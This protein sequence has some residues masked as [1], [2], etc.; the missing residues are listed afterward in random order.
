MN[1]RPSIIVLLLQQGLDINVRRHNLT[2]VGPS[3]LHL[4]VQCGAFDAVVCLV[5]N[6]AQLNAIDNNGW[7]P[8]HCAAFYNQASI[9]EVFLRQDKEFTEIQTQDNL[10][11]TPLLLAATSGCLPTIT[12]LLGYN[13]DVTGC[14]L[15]GH[16]VI[17][18]AVIHGHTRIVQY[19]IQLDMK[20]LP[21]WNILVDM[22]KFED[23]LAQESAV[24]CMEELILTNSE[25]WI[26]IYNSDGVTALANLFDSTSK[27]VVALT[28]SVLCNMTENVEVQKLLTDMNLGPSLVHLLLSPVGD[29][30]ARIS[31]II[32]D[33]ASNIESNQKIFARQGV[34]PALIQLLD[35]DMEDVLLN[36]INAIR[37][38]CLS[39]PSNQ[40]EVTKCNG[41]EPLVD[42]LSINSDNNFLESAAAATLA[43]I[44]LGHFE[45]QN[46]I[47]AAG[48]AE[49]LVN[50]TR[51]RNVM[52][53]VKG[54]R[55]IEALTEKNPN[56]QSVFLKLGAAE[57]LVQ[58]LK[59][60]NGN[61]REQ[62]AC[63]LWALAGHTR[64]QQKIIAETIGI[65]NIIKML[66]E[67][68]SE[69]L[70][71]VGCLSAIGLVKEDLVNQSNMVKADVLQQLVR[72]LN[73]NHLSQQVTTMVVKVLGVLCIGVAYTNNEFVQSKIAE[74]G[75]I[76]V[77][78]QRQDDSSCPEM[79]VEILTT[80][81]CIVLQNQNNQ[82][83]LSNEM[84]FNW[85]TLRNLLQSPKQDI[86]LRSGMALTIFSF[87]N[88]SYQYS[89]RHTGVIH[90]SMYEEFLESPD[91]YFR[92]YA[93]FQI[94]VL[95]RVVMDR[96]SVF[97]TAT[98]VS[99]LV[100]TLKSEDDDVVI[101]AASLLSSLSHTRAGITDAM[102]TVGALEFL[103]KKLNTT[104][105][106]QL[107]SAVAV[108]LGYLTFNPTASRNLFTACRNMP[109]LY[110]TLIKNLKG[111]AKIN[112][113]FIDDFKMARDIGLP[114][115]CLEINGGFPVQKP[116]Q[117]MKVSHW[118]MNP[119]LVRDHSAGSKYEKGTKTHLLRTKSAFPLRQKSP[120]RRKPLLE[121]SKTMIEVRTTPKSP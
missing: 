33:L 23:I 63:A 44:T 108:T 62:G 88:L 70:L 9:L 39:S 19:F 47:V 49:P 8:I 99:I 6:F 60:I 16:N 116:N 21:V 115:Q 56:N 76:P 3:A 1:N 36:A 65:S 28:S 93:A 29:I 48:A 46:F 30:Q 80:L 71:L 2:S 26:N 13:A 98:G 14:N 118:C 97:L 92:S 96:S 94:V 81:A 119:S 57:A 31:I 24:R 103:I 55:A 105:N 85:N 66:L 53:Q 32:S 77:L 25:C 95:A 7:T 86:R 113:K 22:L 20:L 107:S 61:E 110:K 50:L 17:H 72:L 59:S 5:C 102:V 89:I 67:N 58:L 18:T 82:T 15:R 27:G 79:Q 54:A 87:N 68:K 52:L 109:G 114:S 84:K 11:S 111:D 35:S 51:S 121:K 104:S 73:G 91:P 83:L 4:A 12:T 45:N 120:Q 106:P 43:A 41:V 75:A 42:L 101:L 37:V 117:C 34:I 38:M 64:P 100:E 69:K 90:Y 40:T 10:K 74:E 78:I 112:S